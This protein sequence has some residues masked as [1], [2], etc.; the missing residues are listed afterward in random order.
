MKSKPVAC[1]VENCGETFTGKRNLSKH[2]RV[3][4][5]NLVTK[6]IC[7]VC[8]HS[9]TLRKNYRRHIQLHSRNKK[10]E[11]CPYCNQI[12]NKSNIARHIKTKHKKHAFVSEIVDEVVSLVCSKFEVWEVVLPRAGNNEVEG[13]FPISG[14]EG[15]NLMDSQ[16]CVGVMEG[17]QVMSGELMGQVAEEISQH[18]SQGTEMLPRGTVQGADLSGGQG[19]EVSGGQGAEVSSGQGAEVFG[20]KYANAFGGG[21]LLDTEVL[22]GG[23]GHEVLVTGI[24][25]ETDVFGGERGEIGELVLVNDGPNLI[26]EG[27]SLLDSEN[28]ISPKGVTC[29]VCGLS[30]RDMFNLKRHKEKIHGNGSLV[31]CLHSYCNKGGYN[32]IS[33][34]PLLFCFFPSETQKKFLLL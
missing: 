31:K 1:L 5:P 22:V 16:G 29:D 15:G 10:G 4:H 24:G 19:A 2:F 17:L 27:R 33:V 14:F 30:S 13:V 8:T 21:I 6:Y 9:F 20:G 11:H 3:S 32:E 34:R 12:S 25:Q 26:T 7:S 28:G 18:H 23:S